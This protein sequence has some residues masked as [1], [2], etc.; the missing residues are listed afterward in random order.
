VTSLGGGT[1]LFPDGFVKGNCTNK[2]GVALMSVSSFHASAN[3]T[4]FRT[5][6]AAAASGTHIDTSLTDNTEGSVIAGFQFQG[7]GLGT[8]LNG[9]VIRGG[10]KNFV[11]SCAFND[12]AGRALWQPAAGTNGSSTTVNGTLNISKC[13]AQNCL[14]DSVSSVDGVFYLDG[15]DGY[16]T[17]T[18]STGSLSALFDVGMYKNAFYFGPNSADWEGTELLGEFA[19]T[20]FYIDGIRHRFGTLK[21]DNAFGHG[22]VIDCA[23][24]RFGYLFSHRASQETDGTYNGIEMTGNTNIIDSWLVNKRSGTVNRVLNAINETLSNTDIQKKNNYGKTYVSPDTDRTGVIFNASSLFGG[25]Y[26]E[27]NQEMQLTIASADATPDVSEGTF[28][29]YDDAATVTI[30]DFD[31]GTPGQTITIL[32]QTNNKVTFEDNSTNGTSNLFMLNNFDVLML[33]NKAVTFKNYSGVWYQQSGYNPTPLSN[34]VDLT[35]ITNPV[36]TVGKY[37]GRQIYDD[38]TNKLMVAASGS[39]GGAW[40]PTDGSGN[41]T[42]V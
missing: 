35:D 41:I 37:N 14:L 22:F 29:I 8:S 27:H 11:F 2:S 30:T 13:F 25:S 18:E 21:S 1:L 33:D 19:D 20:G 39:A 7:L 28:F 4:V 31:E 12:Y 38:T 9:I 34:T 36:N 17:E 23:R 40:V 10:R 3:P 5:K 16:I 32:T 15:T 24:C 26:F 6:W 42:P